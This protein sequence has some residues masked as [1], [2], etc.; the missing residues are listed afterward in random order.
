MCTS[1]APEGGT[2]FIRLILS[3]KNFM[4][5]ILYGSKTVCTVF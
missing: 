4:F 1:V 5:S 2:V 3:Q